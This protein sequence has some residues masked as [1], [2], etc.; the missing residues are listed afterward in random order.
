MAFQ[1][2]GNYGGQTPPVYLGHPG[3]THWLNEEVDADAA[4]QKVADW[5]ET[6]CCG[7]QAQG[8]L[9]QGISVPSKHDAHY[10]SLRGISCIPSLCTHWAHCPRTLDPLHSPRTLFMGCHLHTRMVSSQ[11]ILDYLPETLS[12]VAV[13][14]PGQSWFCHSTQ[15]VLTKIK[16]CD[17]GSRD[18]LVTT[19]KPKKLLKCPTLTSLGWQNKAM[20]ICH[21]LTKRRGTRAISGQLGP[22]R[23]RTF[24]ERTSCTGGLISIITLDPCI[25]LEES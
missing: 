15:L 18:S 25:G 6:V 1:V 8:V 10:K 19:Q 12:P 21:A 16:Q 22:D 4:V 2:N 13:T 3:G 17:L 9:A 5:R 20:F 23:E 11:I 24:L 7:T 14:S